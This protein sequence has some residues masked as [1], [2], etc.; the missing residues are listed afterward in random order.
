MIK[1]I[2][3]NSKLLLKVVCGLVLCAGI[4]VFVTMCGKDAECKTCTNTDTGS[5]KV[6]CGDELK[7]AQALP[8]VKCL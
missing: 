8:N 3:K 2:L 4:V 1:L 5:T 7:D 6:Y